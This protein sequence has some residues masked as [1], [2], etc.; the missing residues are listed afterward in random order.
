RLTS[1]HDEE[2]RMNKLLILGASALLSLLTA[3]GGGG[4]GPQQEPAAVKCAGVSIALY[5]DSTND[6]VDGAT[7]QRAQPD[8]QHALQ[9]ELD[10]A[11]GP[12]RVGVSNRAISGSAS[13]DLRAIS[14][15]FDVAVVNFGI[16]DAKLGVP[17]ATYRANLRRLY[18][19]GV[20]YK[21]P[22]PIWGEAYD[23]QP[24]AAAMRDVATE[25]GAPVIETN[26]FVLGIDH[27]QA[28]VPD[29]LHPTAELYQLIAKETL[30]VVAP[31]VQ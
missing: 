12:N 13:A 8:P 9:A 14:A 24:Y 1:S 17:L 27:W 21:T 6:G 23:V 5:G 22:N 4:S 30:Q 16:N 18:R 26:G 20:V 19:P 25:L 15:E 10:A 7:H 29:H 2:N 11:L 31:L 28:M 3:C